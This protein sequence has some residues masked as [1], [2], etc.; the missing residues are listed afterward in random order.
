MVVGGRQ[1]AMEEKD[2]GRPFLYS[3]MMIELVWSRDD[4]TGFVYWVSFSSRTLF[5]GTK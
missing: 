2:E 4:R 5:L 3:P 1:E